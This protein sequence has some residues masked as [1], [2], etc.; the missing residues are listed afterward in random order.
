[1][2]LNKISTKC[3]ICGIDVD[4]D[5]DYFC[6]WTKCDDC[7]DQDDDDFIKYRHEYND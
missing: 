3:K 7:M 1:M 4:D 2:G 5:Y 6:G